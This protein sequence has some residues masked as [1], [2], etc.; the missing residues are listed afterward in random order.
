[1]KELL[2]DD[3]WNPMLFKK[4]IEVL[5]ALSGH[6]NILDYKESYINDKYFYL[7]TTL[8]TGG[9]LFDKVKKLKHFSENQ[10]AQVVTT[11]ITAIEHVHSRNIVHRDL[12]PENIVYATRK[13]D[14]EIVIID[15]GDAEIVKG[16]EHHIVPYLT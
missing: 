12:K 5:S 11:V 16:T 6:P 14:S 4:E 1:M 10:A 15:F 3:Q 9:E 13:S 7:C 2:R 8:C